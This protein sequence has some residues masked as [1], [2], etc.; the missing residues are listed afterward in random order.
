MQAE[1]FIHD[2]ATI[3]LVAGII[4]IIFHRFKLP[5]VL[6]YLL[7]GI[8]VGPYTPPFELVH[9]KH[10]IHTLSE[11]GVVLLM[12]SLGL[13]FSLKKLVKV[14][15]SALLTAVCETSLMI[16]LGFNLGKY[17]GWS[18]MDC[19]FL[20]CMIAISST[21]I[22]VK[23]LGEMQLKKHKFAQLIF[24]ILIVED[25]LAIGIIAFLSGIATTGIIGGGDIFGL[26]GKLSLF[27]IVSLIAGLLTIPRLINYIAK[28]N[29]NEMMLISILGLCFGA[30]LLV[31]ALNYSIALGAF[32]MG[33]IIAESRPLQLVE[34]LI[35]PV[36]D[37]FCAIFFIAIGMLF[38]PHI[39]TNYTLQIVLVSLVL[40]FG[41]I[42][43]CTIGA[44]L[45]GQHG[46]TSLKVGMSLAQIGE[47]SFVIASLGATL[48]VTSNILY[49]IAIAA[50]A[51]T[52]LLTPILIKISDPL[53]QKIAILNPMKLSTL[54][55]KYTTW[56]CEMQPKGESAMI[57]KIIAR[58]SLQIIVNCALVAAVF[59]AGAFIAGQIDMV[60][61][62]KT[63]SLT[64]E[65]FRKSIICLTALIVSLPFLIAAYRKFK[66]LSMIL[67]EIIV[68][69]SARLGN[70]TYKI[71]RVIFE[72]LPILAVIAIMSLIFSFCSHVIPPILY[73]SAIC[74]IT[75]IIAA[76]FWQQFV[77]LQS[78]LQIELF[79]VME[80]NSQEEQHDSR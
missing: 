60:Y 4:T 11:L 37:M 53:A 32:I 54:S 3:M 75:L 13:E 30:C 20:G 26:L 1:L 24:G 57:V 2:M 39:V 52:S 7:A 44:F 10:T 38:D 16:F 12:F 5:V 66:A 63:R 25:I 67:A 45:S 8:I 33:A 61:L 42:T 58:I 72:T 71:R 80:D 17:F 49:P 56:I 41:K 22:I 27:I 62:E 51:I 36:R 34:K 76:L 69:H 48:N 43:G 23:T 14:G 70:K 59:I 78:W 46:K 35:E 9:D 79:S 65:D 29:N 21:T 64:N 55:R 15:A 18:Q 19:V 31:M 73:L 40:I 28:Y 68:H 50:S 77:K 47:F 74:G 6:G